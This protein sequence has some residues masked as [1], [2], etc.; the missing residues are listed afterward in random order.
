MF[1]S[2][3]IGPV[4]KNRSTNRGPAFGGK[5]LNNLD[6]D[7]R[8]DR[9]VAKALAGPAPESLP[10]EDTGCRVLTPKSQRQRTCEEM[11]LEHEKKQEKAV[12]EQRGYNFQ[13]PP[14][15]K[16][17][18]KQYVFPNP[19]SSVGEELRSP[20]ESQTLIDTLFVQETKEQLDCL[21]VYD[22]EYCPPRVV[23]GAGSG[24]QRT[25]YLCSPA[26]MAKVARS[27][28]IFDSLRLPT[29]VQDQAEYF[30]CLAKQYDRKIFMKDNTKIPILRG[31]KEQA[32]GLI[33]SWERRMKLKNPPSSK[34]ELNGIGYARIADPDTIA[35]AVNVQMKK[36]GAVVAGYEVP[37]CPSA[38]RPLQNFLET[39]HKTST[40]PFT[41][42]IPNQWSPT[43]LLP[44]DRNSE[45]VCCSLSM[46]SYSYMKVGSQHVHLKKW[47]VAIIPDFQPVE[48]MSGDFLIARVK[49]L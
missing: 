12:F 27:G 30:R 23:Y 5:A 48:F 35:Q 28:P 3:H 16:K 26:M 45:L 37:L 7:S 4:H 11:A 1:K 17:N 40:A 39:I 20:T 42:L 21:E 6:S 19:L 41:Y 31:T 33:D 44:E 14:K 46:T 10:A 8:A 22:I 15:K 9:E 25:T 43:E 18:S 38:M 2:A 34:E 49:D 36:M 32:I 13:L 29:T 47:M 24:F